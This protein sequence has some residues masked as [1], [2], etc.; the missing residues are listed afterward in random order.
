MNGLTTGYQD[1]GS[2]HK[3]IN[4]LDDPKGADKGPGSATNHEK[5]HVRPAEYEHWLRAIMQAE[6]LPPPYLEWLEARSARLRQLEG[7]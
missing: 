1:E 2:Q 6:A 5:N 3:G 7:A 4:N